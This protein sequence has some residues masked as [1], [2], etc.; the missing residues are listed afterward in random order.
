MP[1]VTSDLLG[2]EAHSPLAGS[3]LRLVEAF[4]GALPEG[5]VLVAVDRE[6]VLPPLDPARFDAL[7]TTRADAPAPWVSVTPARLEAQL[8]MVKATAEQC[9]I[10]TAMLARVLRLGA[11]L[12]FEAALEVESLAY[13]ALLG[14]AEFARWLEGPPDEPG[15]EESASPVRYQRE[16][17]V[18][19]L[20]LASP[21][22]RNAMTA[23]MRDALYEA[24]V[25]VLEDPSEPR[26]VLRGEGK[27]FSTG[28][29]L[30]EFGTAKDL[31]KAHVIRTQRSCARVLYRLGNR[32]EV[33][34]H[35]ACIGSGIEVPASAARRIA[36]PDLLVQL[37][38]LVMGL[39]PGAGGTASLNRAIGR[40]RLMWL[41]LGSF[42]IGA[43][44]ARDWGLVDAIEP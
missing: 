12:E 18:V 10:A 20:T 39:I 8:A 44:Q 38:E 30:P 11:G 19:T 37:P 42:R 33:H 43:E 31:A 28:G 21:A 24:L 40:H 5:A 3:P 22:T 36:S 1:L 17:D 25:N 14:G 26:L 9:P 2:A 6:G 29:Y 4:D 15:G 7:V 23:A 13:S 41:A 32:A 27:C 16:G 34:L 35:G